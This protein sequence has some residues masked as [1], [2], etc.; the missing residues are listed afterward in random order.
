MHVRLQMILS[1]FSYPSLL[2]KTVLFVDTGGLK[3]AGRFKVYQLHHLHTDTFQ[4]TKQH[5]RKKKKKKTLKTLWSN[6]S[7]NVTQAPGSTSRAQKERAKCAVGLEW[8]IGCF[9]L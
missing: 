9:G 8:I 1:C 6:I 2:V 3:N 4:L 7:N 5:I